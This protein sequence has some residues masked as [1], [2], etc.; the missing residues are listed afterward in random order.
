ML[1]PNITQGF[2]IGLLGRNHLRIPLGIAVISSTSRDKVTD[3]Y[4]APHLPHIQWHK[5]GPGF[6]VSGVQER[7]KFGAA[8][9]CFRDHREIWRRPVP[10]PCLVGNGILGLMRLLLPNASRFGAN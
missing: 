5:E 4:Y 6:I 7:A 8:V 9:G 1:F 10:Y 3:V 2:I